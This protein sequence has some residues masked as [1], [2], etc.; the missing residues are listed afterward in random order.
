MTKYCYLFCS[1]L[2]HIYP[3]EQKRYLF[4]AMMRTCLSFAR[5]VAKM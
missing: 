3:E 4:S 1:F 2:V 5:V